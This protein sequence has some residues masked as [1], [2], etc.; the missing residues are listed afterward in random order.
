MRIDNVSTQ[1]FKGRF[2]FLKPDKLAP[3]ISED[4]EK[5]LPNLRGK[6]LADVQKAISSCPYDLYISKS[7]DLENFLELNAGAKLQNLLERKKQ[8]KIRPVLLMENKTD[9]LYSAANEAMYKYERSAE[10]YED[11]KSENLLKL[12]YKKIFKKG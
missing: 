6:D 9:R 4:I 10:Y 8:G 7:D 2:L 5:Y 11:T 1:N 12:L 3:T